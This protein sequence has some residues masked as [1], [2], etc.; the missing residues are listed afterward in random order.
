MAAGAG[1]AAAGAAASAAMRAA[2]RWPVRRAAAA[3]EVPVLAYP[4]LREGVPRRVREEFSA[5]GGDTLLE[6]RCMA[7]LQRR[8]LEGG[9]G[10]SSVLL[11]GHAGVGKSVALYA[12]ACRARALGWVTVYVPDPVDAFL[13]Q[14]T[15]RRAAGGAGWNTPEA[16][17]R[18]MAFAYIG[19]GG[20]LLGRVRTKTEGGR[21]LGGTLAELVRGA[22]G[23]EVAPD[24]D[25]D[26]DPEEAVRAAI[27]LRAELDR[28]EPSEAPGAIV[29]ID[30]Y[31]AL[32]G[33]SEFS[34]SVSL[35][36]LRKIPADE[37]RLAAA[38]RT[39]GWRE[40]GDGPGGPG[41]G[42][43]PGGASVVAAT[44]SLQ[45]YIKLGLRGGE[46]R[47]LV[48]PFCPA[49][50][51]T[52][53]ARLRAAAAGGEEVDVLGVDEGAARRMAASCGGNA[54]A[55]RRQAHSFF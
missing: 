34:E 28:V 27:A 48:P 53:M 47:F 36:K 55:L 4:S 12:L 31:G 33:D 9:A 7:A 10:P 18:L 17:L 51:R 8:V 21:A 54:L 19:N 16:A 52:Y 45:Q 11:D 26:R 15:F 44:S 2:A 25:A 23:P 6:R 30:N 29:C 39:L 43:G 50:V 35:K 38:W 3:E 42:P 22:M 14:G 40:G 46:R 20:E 32:F 37:L 24:G 49:E 1:R 41:P 5:A 13:G